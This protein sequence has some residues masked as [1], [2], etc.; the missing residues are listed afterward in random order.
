MTAKRWTKAKLQERLRDLYKTAC[1]FHG[2]AATPFDRGRYHGMMQT[3]NVLLLELFGEDLH[4]A[5]KA[6][7][8]SHD[9]SGDEA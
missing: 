8:V 9:G 1:E 2:R 6:E 4:E 3:V 5:W 7:E